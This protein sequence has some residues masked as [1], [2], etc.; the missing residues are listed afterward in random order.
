[1]YCE[2][3]SVDVTN[4]VF[5]DNTAEDGAGVLNLR[6]SESGE[7]CPVFT[8]CVFSENVANISQGYGGGLFLRS[9][10]YP[11][12]AR[13]TN[14]T[15][16]G[17]QAYHGGGMINHLCNN[18]PVSNCIFWGNTATVSSQIFSY[19]EYDGCKPTFSYCDIEDSY[20]GNGY[21]KEDGTGKKLG[22]DGGGNIDA[23]PD[24]DTADPYWPV[25]PDLAWATTDDSLMLG[26]DSACINVADYYATPRMDITGRLRTDVSANPDMGAYES[27]YKKVIVVMCFI[28]ETL[29]E[30]YYDD[31]DEYDDDLGAYND[32]LA[33]LPTNDYSIIKAGCIV[34]PHDCE[35]CNENIAD[36]LPDSFFYE[37]DEPFPPDILDPGEAP[38]YLPEGLSVAKCSRPPSIDELF[39]HFHR[40]RDGLIPDCAMLLA[41]GSPS[42]DGFYGDGLAF[43]DLYLQTC[44]PWLENW[45]KIYGLDPEEALY[46]DPEDQT[47]GSTDQQDP[48]NERWIKAITDEISDFLSQ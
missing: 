28:D 23:D 45:L 25:G 9:S 21:V 22:S 47:F 34:P 4:C 31:E 32:L 30:S 37:P 44:D 39:V 27:G 14:C 8:N 19:Y 48:D 36:V 11:I 12:S 16:Y 2:D 43:C 5:A 10:V 24:F 20:I 29:I 18:M 7:S 26:A 41:D 15:F 6:S 40:I 1:M 33:S 38:V 17:N 3:S 13:L 42:L 46:A 35:G